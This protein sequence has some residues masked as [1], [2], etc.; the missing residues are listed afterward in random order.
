MN[1]RNLSLSIVVAALLIIGLAATGVHA[2]DDVKGKMKSD[3]TGTNPVNF[4]RESRLYNEHTWLNTEGDGDQN[5]T[6]FEFR[7]P[8]ANGKWQFRMRARYNLLT[9]DY[10]GDGV[11]D[12]DES[13]FGDM[14]VRFITVPYLK[15]TNAIAYGLEAFLD[16]AS[17]DTL[18]K[19][20]TSLGPQIFYAKFFKGGFGPYKGGGMFAPG[21]QYQFSVH[22]AAGRNEID[23][24]NIDLNFLMMGTSKQYWFFTD[25][26]IIFDNEN[27]IEY[28]IVDLEFG[29]MMTMWN[30]DLK[31]HSVYVRPSFGVG[32]GR[33]TDGSIELGYKIVGW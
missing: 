24:I 15:G 1:K 25:P 19:G 27:N 32:G 7:T 2:Q 6:T 21:L 16:T 33:P 12:V 29:V 31:G 28:A 5:V 13:G 9:A 23:Q 11:D 4:Q 22:E 14:D 30:K 18:G 17:E 26:Q 10:D 20:S 8:F 3:K